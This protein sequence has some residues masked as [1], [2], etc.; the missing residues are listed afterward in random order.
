M[1]KIYSQKI[2]KARDIY[3]QE[4]VISSISFIQTGKNP[5]KLLETMDKDMDHFQNSPL[6]YTKLARRTDLVTYSQADL[7]KIS[8]RKVQENIGSGKN[9]VQHCACSQEKRQGGG[10]HCHVA[11]QLTRPKRWKSV[12]DLISSTAGIT[13]N[14]SDSHGN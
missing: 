10:G 13:V 5:F 2:I 12:K 8:T 14:F 3:K 6:V 7:A 4:L 9:R 11:V 1:S